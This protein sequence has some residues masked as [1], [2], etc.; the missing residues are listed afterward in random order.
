MPGCLGPAGSSNSVFQQR[1]MFQRFRVFCRE[2]SGC[3]SRFGHFCLCRFDECAFTLFS[4]EC[5]SDSWKFRCCM[6]VEIAFCIAF[7]MPGGL[8]K[9]M[10]VPCFWQMPHAFLVFLL[11]GACSK[12]EFFKDVS[13]TFAPFVARV[14]T[15][16]AFFARCLIHFP[17]FQ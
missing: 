1:R 7:C 17:R 3:L 15:P 4:N 16:S 10:G 14:L 6:L 8:S 5:F 9:I 11:F 2:W 13:F 12:N